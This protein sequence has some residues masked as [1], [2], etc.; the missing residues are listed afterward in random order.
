[1]P[2]NRLEITAATPRSAKR[3]RRVP[4]KYAGKEISIAFNPEFMMDPL[5]NLT[6]DEVYFELTDELS[7]GVLKCDVPF[8]YVLMPM[9]VTLSGR[10]HGDGEGWLPD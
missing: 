9:R 7:P 3:G 2:K 8:L 5:R 10:S 6:S 1:M 4:I